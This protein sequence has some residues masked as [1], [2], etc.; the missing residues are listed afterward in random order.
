MLGR[1]KLI[2]FANDLR[3]AL[4]SNIKGISSVLGHLSLLADTRCS[5]VMNRIETDR[6]Y[7]R[8]KGTACG[9]NVGGKERPRLRD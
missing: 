1:S 5:Q 9:V 6:G 8:R 2:S 7:F 3:N 4:E